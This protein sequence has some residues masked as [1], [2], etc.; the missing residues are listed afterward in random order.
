MPYATAA[1]M[2]AQIG[3]HEAENL[4]PAEG[5][6]IDEA[7][8]TA[9]LDAAGD[10]IDGYL[11]GRYVLP[12][13]VARSTCIVIARY[14][15]SPSAPPDGR[16]GRDFDRA[17]AYLRDVA[18]GKTALRPADAGGAP[19]GGGPVA[20]GPERVFTDGTLRNY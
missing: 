12:A 3:E 5:G 6:G 7:A 11:A 18:Q 10:E 19:G 17:I 13:G 15:L 1:E 16:I 8:L 4:A 20:V 2:I 14:R 9:A